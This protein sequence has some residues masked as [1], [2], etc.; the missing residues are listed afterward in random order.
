[1]NI[2]KIQK[3]LLSIKKILIIGGSQGAKFFDDF[4]SKMIIKLSKS[5]KIKVLQQ[6]TDQ[7][8]REN[9]KIYIKKMK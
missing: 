2:K 9:I 6:V 7:K 5:S 4:I 8:S 3:K 1:M